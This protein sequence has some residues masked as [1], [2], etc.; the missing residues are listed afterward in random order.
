M[1]KIG[2]N[3][4]R[5]DRVADPDYPVS[6]RNLFIVHPGAEQRSS[7]LIHYRVCTSHQYPSSYSIQ[8]R[9]SL[10][11]H[12]AL[13]TLCTTCIS[14]IFIDSLN[15]LHFTSM[16]LSQM[17][18]TT[19]LILKET[20]FL[21]CLWAALLA[22]Q[23]LRHTNAQCVWHFCYT[24]WAEM[25]LCIFQWPA[26]HGHRPAMVFSYVLYSESVHNSTSYAQLV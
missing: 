1:S 14:S 11:T 12:A 8:K 4:D 13:H 19:F 7:G 9:W 22:A 25:N 6:Q 24:V 21:T 23:N 2:L 3:I 17:K 10:L 26:Q 16:Y 18:E 5:I 20:I 15:G